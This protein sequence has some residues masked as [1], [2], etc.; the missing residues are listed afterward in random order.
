M[1]GWCRRCRRRRR[2]RRLTPASDLQ[3]SFQVRRIGLGLGRNPAIWLGLV[4]SNM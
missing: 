4:R 1:E 3:S 2:G